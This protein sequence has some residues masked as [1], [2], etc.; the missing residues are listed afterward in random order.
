MAFGKIPHE[1]HG[2]WGYRAVIVQK[3]KYKPL[4]VPLTKVANTDQ[5]GIL[6]GMI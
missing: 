5:Y 1:V 2:L 4:K 3:A 6:L